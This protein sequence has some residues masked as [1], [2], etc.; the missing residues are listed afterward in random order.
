MVGVELPGC[1]SAECGFAD[2]GVVQLH[3]RAGVDGAETRLTLAL[4]GAIV[5]AD[6]T[7]RRRPRRPARAEAQAR[8][9]DRLLAGEKLANVR[10]DGVSGWTLRRRR[11]CVKSAAAPR[12]RARNFAPPRRPELS[13][14]ACR[15]ADSRQPDRPRRLPDERAGCAAGPPG[16]RRAERSAP[17][18]ARR[19]DGAATCS[20]FG[21]ATA[22]ALGRRTTTTRTRRS[23]CASPCL[24]GSSLCTPPINF[25]RLP[26]RVLRSLRARHALRAHAT[27]RS[28]HS[29]PA[30]LSA[31]VPA[32]IALMPETLLC[33]RSAEEEHP[34]RGER[35]HHHRAPGG[36]RHRDLGGAS[37]RCV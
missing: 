31:T 17:P 32:M 27:V 16:F 6:C 24:L 30:R 28:S 20:R 22:G 29:T 26:V 10:I 15:A 1:T 5:A 9:V 8:R 37:S 36:V 12:R 35:R 19:Q 33:S 34:N 21:R 18:H 7:S 25:P 14:R 23:P 2:G 11:R 4:R 13:A 3:A